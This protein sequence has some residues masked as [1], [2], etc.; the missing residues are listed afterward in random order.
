MNENEKFIKYVENELSTEEKKKF[1]LKLG[2]DK[3][4][5]N[6]FKQFCSRIDQFNNNIEID[7][8]YFTSLVTKAKE[9]HYKSKNTNSYLPKLTYAIPV[10]LV[11][12]LITYNLFF[13]SS[14]FVDQ[15]YTENLPALFAEDDEL[16][17]EMIDEVLMVDNIDYNSNENDYS[18]FYDND[19]YQYTLLHYLENNIEL[20]EIN[21]SVISYLTENEINLVYNELIDKKIL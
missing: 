15:D 2:E 9:K 19:E 5:A 14:K 20:T 1:D 21:D 4:F 8:R 18:S 3:E 11:A 16:T 17:S 10:F 12:V 6:R 13:V 7:E